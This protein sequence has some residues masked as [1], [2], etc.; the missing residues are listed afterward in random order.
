LLRAFGRDLGSFISIRDYFLVLGIDRYGEIREDL[1]RSVGLEG[2]ILMDIGNIVRT[3]PVP[4]LYGLMIASLVALLPLPP[5]LQDQAYHQ[6]ADQ[7]R[8][9]LDVSRPP[10]GWRCRF[11]ERNVLEKDSARYNLRLVER[12]RVGHGHGRKQGRF[13]G[14][15]GALSAHRGTV[16]V[17]GFLT[18]EPE[19]LEAEARVPRLNAGQG[20]P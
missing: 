13:Q 14:E 17:S 1:V 11:I 18:P 16:P 5:L 12:E 2:A 3:R 7:R 10:C 9:L 4:V 6:F 8:R 15:V 19:T 20:F